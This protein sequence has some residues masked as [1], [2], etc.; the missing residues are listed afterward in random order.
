MAA[1]LLY[2]LFVYPELPDRVPTHWNWVGEADA[3][4]YKSW[5][6]TLLPGVMA[7][8]VAL[9]AALPRLSPAQF[10]VSTFR[11]TFNYLMLVAAGAMGFI[12]IVMLQSA[13]HPQMAASRILI[14][15]LF[16]TLAL[17]GNMLGK[18]R[19]NFWMGVRTPWTLSSDKVWNAT[20]RL[21]AQLFVACG[22]LGAAAVWLGTPAP[23]AMLLLAPAVL[24]PVVQS[25]LLARRESRQ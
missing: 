14:G 21:A 2:T 4:G 22:L 20:H 23:A 16:V 13:L 1:A 19:R 7:L 9:M 11:P 12:H 6:V 25:F 5:A 3:W 15:G 18:V 17:L 8:S 24:I 10:G